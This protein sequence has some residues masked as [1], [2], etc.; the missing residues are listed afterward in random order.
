MAVTA[1]GL[2]A[3][4]CAQPIGLT[5]NSASSMPA[6]NQD[7]YAGGQLR[8]LTYWGVWIGS[9]PQPKLIKPTAAIVGILARTG[10]R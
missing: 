3:N 7:A 2:R 4:R 1:M 6:A 10:S 5:V 9:S 8:K